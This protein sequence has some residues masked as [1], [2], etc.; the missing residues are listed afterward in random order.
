MPVNCTFEVLRDIVS[1]SFPS[2]KL[3]LIKYK[4]DDGDLVT[5]TCTAELRLAE[6]SADNLLPKEPDADK[7]DTTGKLR[8]HIVEVSPEQEPSLLQEEERNLWR[9]KGIRETKVS[10]SSLRE[11]VMETDDIEIDKSEKEAP[12]E[13]IGAREDPGSREVEMDDW[14]FEFSLLFQTHVG[15]Y[16][17]AHVDLHELG[18]ELCSGALQETV[19]TGKRIPLDESAGKEKIDLSDWDPTETL[20]LFDS[21][22]E[23]MKAATEI[24]AQGE[25]SPE[26]AAEQ[27]TVMRSQIHLF[28]GNI[29]FERSQVECKLGMDGWKKNPDTAVERFRLAGASEADISMVLKNHCSNGDAVEGDEKRIRMVM[30]MMVVNQKRAKRLIKYK[31]SNKY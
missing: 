21:A 8:L 22:E 11:S 16:L 13:K 6:S 7:T 14:L 15:I 3:V 28:W 31:G 27:A 18:M 10:H 2:S 5:I 24:G 30:L 23:E 17:D 19:I 12:K 4:D 1:K 20:T 25:I 29:L 26:E 9:P